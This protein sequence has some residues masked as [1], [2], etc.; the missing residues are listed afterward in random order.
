[1]QP[2]G[3]WKPSLLLP[4]R[5]V[6]VWLPPGYDDPKNSKVRYE[7]L[8][9]HDGQNAMD[10]DTSW[11]GHSWRLGAAI[12]KLVDEGKILRPPVVVLID[13]CV[14]DVVV[15]MLR[16]RHL[17]YGDGWWAEAYLAAVCDQLVPAVDKR[18]R[19]LK[20]P[21]SRAQLGT[22][23]GGQM[24]FLGLWRRPDVFLAAAC[25]SPA[26][27]SALLLDVSSGVL[28]LGDK[29]GRERCR[30]LALS[31]H[32]VRL[33]LD[34]GGD[35]SGGASVP[36]AEA[37]DVVAVVAEVAGLNNDAQPRWRNRLNPGY[38]WLDTWLQPG[39]DTMRA[40][41]TVQGFPSFAYHK[42]PGARHNERAWAA[43]IRRPLLHLYG[44]PEAAAE[45]TSPVGASA[46][47]AATN[48]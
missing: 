24:A 16:R 2:K 9:V 3:L 7:T 38:F 30:A 29:S 11:T 15:P 6:K 19:T 20:G 14:G 45:A 22:S 44:H 31:N 13:N 47:S 48:T 34:N 5:E 12:T 32:P 37:A 8:Y 4:D 10:D 25:L 33:Y 28:G 27:Q 42:E 35:V 39:V 18:F 41:L 23:L 21:E 17:E 43:R 36:L 26:F 40:L 1:V 46:T